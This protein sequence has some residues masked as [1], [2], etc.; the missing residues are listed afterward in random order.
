MAL[1]NDRH[2]SR[3][4]LADRLGVSPQTMARLLKEG[5]PCEGTGRG[6]RFP[7]P[8]AREW[9]DARREALLRAQLERAEGP[10]DFATARAR[11]MAAEAE[12]A[13]FE[14][15]TVRR[16]TVLVADAA[17]SVAAAFERVRARF[18]AVPGTHALR[19]VELGSPAEAQAQLEVLVDEVLTALS[20]ADDA[21]E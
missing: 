7:W 10:A 2:I 15:A 16:E 12:L 20:G 1:T 8:A 13:E 19:F 5:L 11:K 18:T 17:R 4:E 14:L 3:A 6:R 9:Y 21:G